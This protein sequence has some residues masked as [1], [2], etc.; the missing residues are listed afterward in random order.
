MEFIES[1]IIYHKEPKGDVLLGKLLSSG[2]VEP[3]M[4]I[5]YKELEVVSV[6][7]NLVDAGF[8]NILTGFPESKDFCSKWPGGVGI[9]KSR[10]CHLGLA[11]SSMK[12]RP[13][14]GRA[15]WAGLKFCHGE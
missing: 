2:F 8:H 3:Y 15:V 12:R 4:L 7:D 6:I 11:A 14:V 10:C 5:L 9:W 13:G 1:V